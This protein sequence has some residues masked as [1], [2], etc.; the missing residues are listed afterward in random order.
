[1]RSPVN[2]KVIVSYA[3]VNVDFSS[4]LLLLAHTV[5]KFWKIFETI[6]TCEHEEWGQERDFIEK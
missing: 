3:N 5:R 1:M 4:V 2:I 6:D